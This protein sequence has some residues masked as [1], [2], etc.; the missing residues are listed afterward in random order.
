MASGLNF[1]VQYEVDI[2]TLGNRHEYKLPSA[3][4]NLPVK[5]PHFCAPHD[6]KFNAK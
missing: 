6:G 1:S 2:S 3:S 4:S 5:S